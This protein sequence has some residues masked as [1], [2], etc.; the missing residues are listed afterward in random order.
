M[1][2]EIETQK[3]YALNVDREQDDKATEI[4]L[5]SFARPHMRAFHFAWWGFFIAFFIWFAIAP[6]LPLIKEDLGLTAQDIWT[7]NI[8]AVAF[9]ICMR[10]VFGAICDKY[11]ARV[12]MGCVLML[13]SIPTACIGLVNS[14]TGLICIRLFIGLAGSTF[15]MCQC[16]AT[17]MFTKEIVGMVNGLVGGWGNVGGG[18]TQLVMGTL[19]FPLFKVITDGDVS[20]AWR[21]VT[22]VPAAVAFITGICVIC[23]SEDCP[24]GYYKDLKKSG[25]MPEVSAAASFRGG[26]VDINTW[27][28]FIQYACCFGV[29]LTVNNAAVSYFVKRFELTIETASAI[30]SIFGFMNLFARGVGGWSSDQASKK[31]KMRGRILV[32]AGL[33]ILEGCCIFIFA[34]M[35]NLAASVVMLTIFSIFVQGAEGSTY[36]IVPY[37]NRVSPGAVAGIVGAG[38]PTGAVCFGLV[39]RQLPE[40]PEMAFRIMAGVVLASGVMCLFINIKGHRGLLFGKDEDMDKIQIPVADVDANEDVDVEAKA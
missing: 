26:A 1:S 24:K 34:E 14:L 7:T 10:F 27:M 8:C 39:F 40:D 4:K 9:D 12:P 6:L 2:A 33:L 20:K 19:L 5:C 21:T 3:E 17:R 32:Q 15:V 30:A 38:G 28:L 35:N 31:L 11:G 29:E 23:F 16:W 18:A 36:G 25:E 37:V 13:A 22:L